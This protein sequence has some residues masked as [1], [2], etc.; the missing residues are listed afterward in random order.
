MD[1]GPK[2][3]M[4]GVAIVSL[5]VGYGLGSLVTGQARWQAGMKAGAKEKQAEMSQM[6]VSSGLLPPDLPTDT[7]TGKI[8]ATSGDIMTIEVENL[9]ANPFS[10]PSPALRKVKINP[11]SIIEKIERKSSEQYEKDINE[12]NEA[13]RDFRNKIN[14]GLEAKLPKPVS[15]FVR[16]EA[17]ASDLAPGLFVQVKSEDGDIRITE[18]FTAS[19]VEIRDTP[20]DTRI[21]APSEIPPGALMIMPED[22]IPQQ[23]GVPTE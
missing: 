1:T 11:D 4:L 19:S 13:E 8:S 17:K 22:L 16:K 20:F 10:A 21:G 5:A 6:L 18:S 3:I 2:K 23:E 14:Q 7:I 9:N 12:F 15:M